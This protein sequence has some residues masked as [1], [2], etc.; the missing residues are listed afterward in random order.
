[1]SHFKIISQNRQNLLELLPL[2]KPLSIFIETTNICNFR[3]NVCIQ[4]AEE[5]R[6]DLAPFKHMDFETFKKIIDDIK[7]WDGPKL[8]LLRLAF[9]GEPFMQKDFAKYAKYAVDAEISEKVDTFSN[10]SL[11]N[12]EQAEAILDSGIDAIRFSI[13]SVIN[14]RH[15]EVTRKDVPVETIRDNILYLKQERD[16][17]K[18][19]KPFIFVK[20]FDNY[21]E[22]NEIFFSLY[23]D[24]ADKIDLEKVHN[25][26]KYKGLDIMHKYYNNES[27]EKRNQDNFSSNL[28]NFTACPRPFMSMVINVHGKALMCTLDAPSYTKFGDIAE[29]SLQEIWKSEQA[30]NFRKLQLEGKKEENPLCRECD[31][32]KLFP[33]EDCVDGFPIDR[34]NEF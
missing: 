27:I 8:K 15:K 3:C 12:K 1:M 26:T 5:T 11:M 7:R 2:K 29:N 10:A 9:H 20:A 4:G 16:R 30:L 31:W 22:E 23:K 17:R 34:L 18:L 19:E 13:Y 21:N 33:Q 6:K 32:F 28:H 25:G 24:I 14:Q